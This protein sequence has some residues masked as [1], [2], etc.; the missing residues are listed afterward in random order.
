MDTFTPIFEP[1]TPSVADRKRT[2]NFSIRYTCIFRQDLNAPRGRPA[3]DVKMR[4]VCGLTVCVPVVP[5]ALHRP[6]GQDLE[7]VPAVHAVQLR[8]TLVVS[9]ET[10][11][12]SLNIEYNRAVIRH[13]APQPRIQPGDPGCLRGAIRGLCPPAVVRC[14]QARGRAKDGAEARSRLL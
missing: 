8:Q 4:S 3:L 9:R 11:T 6:V 2:R 12:Y 7:V 14:L 13:H 10:A 5:Q 1:D